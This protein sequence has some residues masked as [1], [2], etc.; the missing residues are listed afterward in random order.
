M[1]KFIKKFSD[2][3]D[4][5]TFI[6][7]GGEDPFVRPNVSYCREENDVHYN[8]KIVESLSSLASVG[9]NPSYVEW[10][11]TNDEI[12]Y[13]QAYYNA[14]VTDEQCDI[15]SLTLSVKGGGPSNQVEGYGY[16]ITGACGHWFDVDENF[17]ITAVFVP[18]L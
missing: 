7:G 12:E 17:K 5:Q 8:K 16:Y 10:T 1:G 13:M 15:S 14:N 18:I 2:H 6:G 3:A 9:D 4:Y 11:P